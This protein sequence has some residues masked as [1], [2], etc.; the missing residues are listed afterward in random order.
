M[1]I[2]DLQAT[3]RQFAAD[4]DWQPFQ[5]PKNLA[6]A[7]IVEAAELAEIFQW[8]TGEQSQQAWRDAAVKQHIGEEVADVLLYLLQIA[9]H[10]Q[11][12][13]QRAVDA[14]LVH[15]ARKYPPKR[16]VGSLPPPAVVVSAPA[17]AGRTHVL[18]DYENVQP[19]AQALR[20]LVPDIAEVWLFHGPHQKNPGRHL[21]GLPLTLVPISKTGKN[22]LDFHL[23]F[24]VGFISS[25][26]PADKIVVVANDQGY[27]PMLMHARAMGFDVRLQ[28]LLV[29]PRKAAA[30][31]TIAAKARPAAK[32][33]AQA[34][35]I[36][37]PVL[38]AV[39]VMKRV[40]AQVAEQAAAQPARSA[41][42]AAPATR[43]M[44]KPATVKPSGQQAVASRQPQAQPVK[45]QPAK[46]QP[47]KPQPA[48]PQPAGQRP[49]AKSP[50]AK[51]AA[52][53][54]A[55]AQR[56]AANKPAEAKPPASARPDSDN[57]ASNSAG[58]PA[59]KPAAAR[60]AA[61]K[62][63]TAKPR[64][65]PPPAPA[66]LPVSPPATVPA[67]RDA[68]AADLQKLLGRLRKSGEQR[69]ATRAPLLRAL[70]SWLGSDRSLDE[71][72][73][74]LQQLEAAGYLDV[75]AAGGVSYQL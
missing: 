5:T 27:E 21:V 62:P 15:N 48:K 71:A 30:A 40:V 2:A 70:Q 63:A 42:P 36:A 22:A 37:A 73:A 69:P 34:G 45:P 54:G 68:S 41:A 6:M 3:L 55:A 12:D 38:P 11:I 28:P 17:P 29:A 52:M 18:L 43:A 58:N 39:Q 16:P 49:A 7:M 47:A 50:A 24:Y 59:A 1:N 61:S 66:V 44:V 65:S 74:A 60:P 8:M 67:A 14:K 64:L 75:N 56:P 33:R 57:S 46:P 9:D 23:T 31:K 35:R 26:H 4:R 72:A 20:T 32:K 13:V 51:R 25:R 53:K 10:S 19:D